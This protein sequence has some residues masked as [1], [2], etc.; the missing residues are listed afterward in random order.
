MGNIQYLYN[1]LIDSATLT[2]SS[3]A[4]GFAASNIQNPFRGKVWRTAGATAGTANLVID[5]SGITRSVT[6]ASLILNGGFD[7]AATSWAA[8]ADETI[9]SVAG[10][11]AGNCLQV[12]HGTGATD[13]VYQ[14]VTLTLGKRYRFAAY[15]KSGTSGNEAYIVGAGDLGVEYYNNASGTSSASWVAV[16]F[17]FTAKTASVDIMLIKN[18]NTAGTMLF[19]TV[20][21]YELSGGEVSAVALTGYS[22]A[23]APGTLNLE[24]N[25][26]NSWGSPAVTEAL[27]W[28]ASPS[29]NGNKAVIIKE[30]TSQ[31]YLYAR[32]SVVYSPGGTPTD[33]DLGRMFLGPYFEPT[34]G[35]LYDYT[36]DHID[37]SYIQRSVGGQDHVDEIEMYRTISFS[38][39]IQT[40]AQ[41]ELFQRMVNAVGTKKDLFIAFNY[42]DEP[43]EMTIYG[44]FT[45][46]PG[47]TTYGLG[48]RIALAFKESR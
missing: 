32:L 40:Q 36:E 41:Y 12:T 38:H 5:M 19:D 11:Q 10:G 44:K 6:G 26:A 16:T 8:S 33:W 2:G 17:D 47:R 34:D 9:A 30:F 37:E 22:W 48:G 27:T 23:S 25:N 3:T 15:V 46:L 4:T 28:Y 14:T 42:A 13:I 39:V 29:A 20:T 45:Q 7:S 21:L 35:Y 24:F 31:N 1:N 18:T 43:D